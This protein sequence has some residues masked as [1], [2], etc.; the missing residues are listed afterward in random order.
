[1]KNVDD[2]KD[3][4]VSTNKSAETDV[5]LAQIQDYV[6][7]LALDEDVTNHYI[8][9]VYIPL[10]D[11]N[12]PAGK[13]VQQ[14]SLATILSNSA[15]G[16]GSGS[17]SGSGDDTAYYTVTHIDEWSWDS[18]GK[19][20]AEGTLVGVDIPDKGITDGTLVGT[21]T[22]IEKSPIEWTINGTGVLNGTFNVTEMTISGFTAV[23]MDE[24]G[25]G[26]FVS[27]TGSI[28]Y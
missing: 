25:S 26:S 7:K 19:G 22:L 15:S 13:N 1:M 9:K 14:I 17:S 20:S 16:K 18:F 6:A 10:L 28:R 11:L 24:N 3:I 21:F 27:A 12:Q 8:T 4:L 5:L 23:P 2:F